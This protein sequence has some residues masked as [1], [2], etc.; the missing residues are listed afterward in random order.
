MFYGLIPKT[1]TKIG[2]I[3]RERGAKKDNNWSKK[4]QYFPSFPIFPV[5]QR[6]KKIKTWKLPKWTQPWAASNPDTQIEMD[7]WI[8]QMSLSDLSFP[9]LLTAASQQSVLHLE[10]RSTE[11][12]R[13]S[14]WRSGSIT[15]TGS[16]GGF[17]HQNSSLSPLERSRITQTCFGRKHSATLDVY[18]HIDILFRNDQYPVPMVGLKL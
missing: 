10:V 7:F 6:E 12:N 15:Q 16:W 4:R 14:G 18:R 8:A 2:D 13:I 5:Q 11:H 3:H 9:T 17:R 1:W